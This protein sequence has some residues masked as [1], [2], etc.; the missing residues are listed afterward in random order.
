MKN[1]SFIN[2]DESIRKN[3][4]QLPM[5][6]MGL[7]GLRVLVK[8]NFPESKPS[9]ETHYH[10]NAMEICYVTKGTQIYAT[11]DPLQK[12]RV[13]RGMVFLTYPNE[14]HSTAGMLEEKDVELYFMVID[15]VNDL[16]HFL[17]FTG[18]DAKYLAAQ[19]N[20]L[21]RCF[22]VGMK[23]K[24]HLDEMIRLYLEKPPMCSLALRCHAVLAIQ[25]LDSAQ[26]RVNSLGS[27]STLTLDILRVLNRIEDT[28]YGAP[29]SIQEMADYVFMSVPA[30]K[31][32]FK[33]QIGTPPFEYQMKRRIE[34]SCSLIESG[35]SVSKIAFE[36]GFSS[37]QHFSTA[38]RKHMYVSPREW[39]KRNA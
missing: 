32:K 6:R 23:L 25:E 22:Y 35:E 28:L 38:F 1:D 26:Q 19:L 8:K 17:G 15:T 10:E 2:S 27:K 29:L 7:N 13:S 34:E 12:Y 24:S 11:E 21:N 30:F 5:Y 14:P 36:L 31:Q 33:Q 4:T 16:E 20:S 9:L 37:S 3:Y 39:K 18:I